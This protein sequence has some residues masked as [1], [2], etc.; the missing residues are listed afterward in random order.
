[1]VDRQLRPRPP[2]TPRP[3][4]VYEVT[5]VTGTWIN[6]PSC[7]CVSCKVSLI[8]TWLSNSNLWTD[9]QQ[10]IHCEGFSALCLQVLSGLLKALYAPRRRRKTHLCRCFTVRKNTHL[11]V[12][13]GKFLSISKWLNSKTTDFLWYSLGSGRQNLFSSCS[14]PVSCLVFCAEDST[15][16]WSR[17]A[18]SARLNSTNC[19]GFIQWS[20]AL[21]SSRKNSVF[22]KTNR[23]R[24][25]SS[26]ARTRTWAIRM[27]IF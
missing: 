17:G 10:I 20:S 6:W 25:V 12:H 4:R 8:E 9:V 14:F 18:S 13:A 24:S 23:I 26:P 19:R 5:K 7:V 22:S 11:R 1:M 27:F 21:S 16:A 2:P 3:H 15:P